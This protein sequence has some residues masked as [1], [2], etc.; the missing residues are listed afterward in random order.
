MK[1]FLSSSIIPIYTGVYNMI[2]LYV[3]DRNLKRV[4]LID[5][6][7]SMIWAN[8]YNDL[9]SCELYLAATA[10]NIAAL[11][12]GNYLVR[13]DDEMICRID[14]VEIDTDVEEGNY[15]IVNGTDAKALLQQRIIDTTMTNDGNVEDFIRSMVDLTICAPSDPARK[16]KKDNG[17]QLVFLGDKANLTAANTDQILHVNVGEKIKEYCKT[18]QYGYCMML[19]ESALFFSL[20]A[21][22]DRSSDVIFSPD[23]ENLASSKYTHNSTNLGNVALISSDSNIEQYGDAAGVDRYELYIDGK[24][25]S[26]EITW[27]ELTDTYPTTAE[28]GQGHIVAGGTEYRYVM[29][30]IDIQILTDEQ[31]SWLQS[32]FPGG[33]IITVDDAQYYRAANVIIATLDTN[34]PDD[35]TKVTL[36]DVIYNGYLLSKGAQAVSEYGDSV[37]FD[38]AIIPDVTFIYKKDYFLGD[39]VNVK[40]EYGIEATARIVEVIEVLDDNGYSIQPKFE[41]LS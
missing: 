3:L 13:L 26:R 6:Y 23:Y 8:R 14:R 32:S 30:I 27:S 39:L 17:D 1:T 31:L 25:V 19:R 37:S 18:Y 24:D 41:Y 40:N 9:G 29:N 16:M 10:D 5:S 28:G 34:T 20:Y 11:T 36:M 35:N 22:A 12:I 2:E 4:G 7:R 38:G 15:L 21:G 33:T